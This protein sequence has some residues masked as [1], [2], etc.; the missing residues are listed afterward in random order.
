MKY[1]IKTL[2]VGGRK[3][4]FVLGNKPGLGDAVGPGAHEVSMPRTSEPPQ[5]KHEPKG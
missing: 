2:G 3:E 1:F 5:I 4:S